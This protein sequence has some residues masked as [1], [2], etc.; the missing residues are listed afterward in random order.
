MK[1]D[2]F[3]QGALVVAALFALL[4]VVTGA[5]ASAYLLLIFPLAAGLLPGSKKLF[6]RK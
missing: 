3:Q 1:L 4:F 5:Q 6:K 2:G